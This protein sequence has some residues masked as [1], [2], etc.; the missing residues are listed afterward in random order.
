MSP[1]AYP[2]GPAYAVSPGAAGGTLP[3]GDI[4]WRNFLA[5]A[6]L[7]Q[8]VEIALQNNRD[9]RTAVLNVAQVQAQYRIQRA[10][11]Y[12]QVGGFADA[13]R[14][15]TPA[16]LSSTGK[17]TTVQDYSVGLSA[18][19]EIDF[20]GRLQSLKDAALQQYL[21]TAHARQAAEILLVSQVADQYLTM[22]ALDEQLGVTRETPDAQASYKIVSVQF[23]TGT[24]PS[25]LAPRSETVVE[26]ANVNYAAQVASP[27]AAKTRVSVSWS[28]R[29]RQY[30][31]PQLRLGNRRSC[32]IPAGGC[33]RTLTRRPTSSSPRR[34]C[35]RELPTSAPAR[36]HSFAPDQPDRM[37][38]HAIAALGGL[39]RPDRSPGPSAIDHGC[40]LLQA[41]QTPHL[42]SRWGSKGT[43][44]LHIR[45]GDPER[46]SRSCG[47][48]CCTRYER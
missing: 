27:C 33:H 39:L 43:S 37:L 29:S 5:D 19:W 2:T 13:S 36:A 1:R 21:A 45:E 24:A 7:Q 28:N 17:S 14:T 44:G 32:R 12:P 16:S 10:A 34:S 22:L 38:W 30:L 8:L 40:R 3:A 47:R 25:F 42:G 15:R 6:R 35:V 26:Q 11:L 23:D 9:L 18:A 31:P 4:G 41:A 20:F 46:F 48:P